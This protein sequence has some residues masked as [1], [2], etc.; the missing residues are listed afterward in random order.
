MQVKKVGI[1]TLSIFFFILILIP[2]VSAQADL[3]MP[4]GIA[5]KDGIKQQNSNLYLIN[6]NHFI[7]INNIGLIYVKYYSSINESVIYFDSYKF[8]TLTIFETYDKS[9][10]EIYDTNKTLIRK[11]RIYSSSFENII[12]Y[13]PI[14]FLNNYSVVIMPASIQAILLAVSIHAYKRKRVI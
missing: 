13:G 8:G 10:I 9:I 1:K 11:Y 4:I 3:D 12:N 5:D 7:L 6:G 14:S 2:N